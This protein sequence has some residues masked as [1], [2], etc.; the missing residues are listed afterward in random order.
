MRGG[1]GSEK[2]IVMV[3]ELN[4]WEYP[5][6]LFSCLLQRRTLYFRDNNWSRDSCFHYETRLIYCLT[7]SHS[8][9]KLWPLTATSRLPLSAFSPIEG[10]SSIPPSGISIPS[11]PLSSPL[12]Y[13]FL[14]LIYL[15]CFFHPYKYY[16]YHTTTP[17]KSNQSGGGNQSQVHKPSA[18]YT[19]G[20]LPNLT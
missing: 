1:I 16:T 19:V 7:P 2:D 10:I 5:R 13:H 18:I 12:H 15:P 9:V 14:S 17:G 6:Q 4:H 3:H 20:T 8:L 11:P